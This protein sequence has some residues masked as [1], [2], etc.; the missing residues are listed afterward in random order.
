[1][2]LFGGPAGRLVSSL[3][4]LALVSSVSSMV[5]AGPRVYAAMAADR[6]LPAVMARRTR[7]GVPLVAVLL[8]GALAFLFV[9]FFRRI[10]RLIEYIGFA[11]ALFTTLAVGSLFVFRAR[12]RRAK[13]AA[14]PGAYRTWGYP[15]TPLLYMGLSMW[16]VYAQFRSHWQESAW[17]LATLVVGGALYAA[18]VG[19]RSRR[20]HTDG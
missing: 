20:P 9:V 3:I 13:V 17:V 14:E 7:R 8:Q 1:V 6:A 19:R 4:A 16:V 11:L 18:T 12:D 2:A 15:V 10:D 5:M